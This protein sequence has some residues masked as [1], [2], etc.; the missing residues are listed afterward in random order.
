M[1]RRAV[2]EPLPDFDITGFT[3]VTSF[4]IADGFHPVVYLWVG[5]HLSERSWV[6]TPLLKF[7]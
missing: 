1:T 4:T 3:E 5:K 6:S 7:I 2:N